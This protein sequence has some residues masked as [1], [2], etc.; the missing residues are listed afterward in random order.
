MT[1][2]TPEPGGRSR[3]T[4]PRSVIVFVLVSTSQ[5]ATL[6]STEQVE[7]N[8]NLFGMISTIFCAF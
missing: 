8:F 1:K 5:E 3:E 4:T 7:S 6:G 2:L